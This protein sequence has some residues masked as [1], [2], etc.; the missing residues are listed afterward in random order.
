MLF[1]RKLFV[2]LC[3]FII[4]PYSSASYIDESANF[5]Y[6]SAIAKL[7]WPYENYAKTLANVENIKVT[8][9]I[10]E[11]LDKEQTL[12]LDISNIHLANH[13]Y[14][15]LSAEKGALDIFSKEADDISK[16]AKLII[17]TSAGQ[18][19][20]I[21]TVDTLISNTTLKSLGEK[22]YFNVGNG[23]YSF[24]A[25]SI[26]SEILQK[27]LSINGIQLVLQTTVRQ[28]GESELVVTQLLFSNKLA[29]KKRY[30]IANNYPQDRGIINNSK[31]Y[32]ADNFNDH[33]L[34][35][36]IKSFFKKDKPALEVHSKLTYV[37]HNELKHYSEEPGFAI[38]APF[39]TEKNLA[40]NLDYY[41][42][43][44]LNFEPEEVYFRYYLMLGVGSKVS[45]GGKL[46]GF[47]GTYN[48]AGWGG[49]GNSGYNGWSARGAF[50]STI[51][52]SGHLL[53][54]YMP[55]GQYIYEVEHEKYGKTIPWGDELSVI[56]P[57]KWYA[58]EQRLKLNTPGLSDGILEAWVDGVK[59]FSE[60]D[61]NL[62]STLA[63]KI[64]KIWF[65]FYFG[66][67]DKPKSD[68]DIYIDN[69]VIASSYIGPFYEG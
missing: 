22:S 31:V 24:L 57:G 35:N 27:K 42:Y 38:K 56:K 20:L 4:Q 13:V 63:L 10:V 41:F 11:D 30:G 64:E 19:T 23:N 21:P 39:S 1:T 16:S 48:K 3:Y 7:N 45:G 50:F 34:L 2:C 68:F 14:F 54:G 61:V 46:P 55:I 51:D 8:R 36:N 9:K 47:G 62:R 58:I 49:R 67:V 44:H 15:N 59:V 32:F 28:Y 52:K 37:K 69:I 29:T 17:S 25:F 40:L 18:M 66:G 33:N 43:K 65:N 5:Y 6:R 26:P 12:K 53:D 60:S